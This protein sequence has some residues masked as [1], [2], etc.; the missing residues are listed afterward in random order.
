MTMIGRWLSSVFGDKNRVP[1]EL[2]LSGDDVYS[3]LK[4]KLEADRAEL[5]STARRPD[6]RLIVNNAGT[7]VVTFKN[8][9]GHADQDEVIPGE[10]GKTAAMIMVHGDTLSEQQANAA[11]L[12]ERYGL[13]EKGFTPEFVAD[14]R[15]GALTD[16]VKEAYGP[17]PF[18]GQAKKLETVSWANEDG[19]ADDVEPV[20]GASA[21]FGARPPSNEQVF[22]VRIPDN[23]AP[24]YLKGTGTSAEK[25]VGADTKSIAVGV[26]PVL[27]DNWQPTGEVTTKPIA[28]SVAKHFYGQGYASI[29]V[30]DLNSEGNVVAVNLNP[31]SWMIDDNDPARDEIVE[32]AVK[33]GITGDPDKAAH[34]LGLVT[35][36]DGRTANAHV[37]HA[38]DP[39][40]TDGET[41]VMINRSRDPGA[42]MPA[43]PG[44]FIDPSKGGGVESAVQAAAREA[45][46][47]VGVELGEGIHVGVRNMERPYDV[48]VAKGDGLLEKYGIADGD[49]FMVSTQG[50]RF[51][52]PDL[53]R[54]PLIAGD[55]AQPGSARRVEIGQI[56]RTTVGIP[57]HADMVHAAIPEGQKQKPEGW[58]PP[59]V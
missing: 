31:Q 5:P 42:G 58:A 53:S 2:T 54:T 21:A 11:T 47:E 55:D 36:A 25:L 17:A 44:G 48:R 29:P 28:L 22:V 19:S 57:D 49:V 24:V 39:I 6:V 3:Q 14:L 59:E 45:L 30:I 50:V 56:T 26:S 1:Q 4:A 33:L 23:G 43:L 16:I 38:V 41:V 9:G 32:R 8:P 20:V 27:D 12:D 10:G 18:E 46:E 15:S 34:A 52:V 40:I 13:S 7:E 51:N 37:V 35:L